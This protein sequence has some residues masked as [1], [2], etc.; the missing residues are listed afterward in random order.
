MTR[1]GLLSVLLSLSL[2]DSARAIGLIED[3]CIVLKSD[4]AAKA[5]SVDVYRVVSV[6][7]DTATV[8]RW[9]NNA[10]IGQPST[11]PVGVVFSAQQVQCPKRGADGKWIERSYEKRVK[12]V[13][14]AAAQ[15]I[16][17]S[18][19]DVVVPVD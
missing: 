11:M 1:Y 19:D 9:R 4:L 6:V 18:L 12:A 13:A 2:V 8:Q 10:A 7:D 3:R 17:I 5:A 14:A 16:D 15:G